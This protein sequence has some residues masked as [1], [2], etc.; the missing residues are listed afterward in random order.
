MKKKILFGFMVC[1]LLVSCQFDNSKNEEDTKKDT[2]KLSIAWNNWA[3]EKDFLSKSEQLKQGAIAD[4]I[5]GSKEVKKAEELS[6]LNDYLDSIDLSR[7]D[8]EYKEKMGFG[9]K[10]LEKE[11]SFT[12]DT[13]E[14]YIYYKQAS[15]VYIS[16]FTYYS[17][18]GLT[19]KIESVVMDADKTVYAKAYFDYVNVA[20]WNNY[21]NGVRDS[22]K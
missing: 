13:D 8:S 14:R 11:S 4:Y 9:D 19:D 2:Y 15:F 1:L 17:D 18:E 20:S 7:Y 22:Y 10:E 6:E 12:F 5:Y 3:S 21:A 16:S